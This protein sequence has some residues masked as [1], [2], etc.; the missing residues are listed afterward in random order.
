MKKFTAFLIVILAL[1]SYG[2]SAKEQVDTIRAIE[3][4]LMRQ[5]AAS[6]AENIVVYDSSEL[7]AEMLENRNGSLIVERCIGTVTNAENGDGM[8][9]NSPD[10]Q[11]SYIGYRRISQPFKNG[12]VVLSYM[13]YD[14]S[15][16]YVDDI[17]ERYDFVLDIEWRRLGEIC[18][19]SGM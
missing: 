3:E 11:F 1:L 14:P 6:G 4:S 17:Y 10:P 5:L 12:M 18:A 2:C 19:S 8:M 9:F 16:N 15:N 7:T 13:V